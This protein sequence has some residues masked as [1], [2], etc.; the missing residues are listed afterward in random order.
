MLRDCSV[1]AVVGFKAATDEDA[2]RIPRYMQ[3]HGYR[4][5]PVNPKLARGAPVGANG[6]PVAGKALGERVYASLSEV[7]VPVDMVNLFRASEN[8]PA[9]VEEILAMSP[10]P[11]AVWMQLGIVNNGS[12]AVLRN[13]GIEVVQDRCLMVEHR[14]L[15]A[16]A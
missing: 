6:V 11:K 15:L 8:I 5:L 14:R 1:I 2:Y 16:S 4:V 12:A 13:E 7:D 9:H 10:R 3:R